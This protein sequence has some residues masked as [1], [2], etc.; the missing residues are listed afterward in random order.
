[1]AARGTTFTSTVET[2][3]AEP[4]GNP[5]PCPPSEAHPAA[6]RNA[7]ATIARDAKELVESKAGPILAEE[8]ENH[9]RNNSMRKRCMLGTHM[10]ALA[11][12]AEAKEHI[13]RL[14]THK[15]AE[16]LSG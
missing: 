5:L 8:G 9:K 12:V 14:T 10:T 3:A 7:S 4:V 16:T 11:Q 2:A 1:M 13:S 6:K 15:R